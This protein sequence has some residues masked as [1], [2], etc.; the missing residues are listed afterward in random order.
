MKSFKISFQNS[1]LFNNID[2][3][4]EVLYISNVVYITSRSLM[5]VILFSFQ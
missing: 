5:A 2:S 1:M 3:K 4:T